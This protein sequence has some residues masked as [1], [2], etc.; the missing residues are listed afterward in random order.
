MEEELHDEDEI[1]HILDSM[2]NSVGNFDCSLHSSNSLKGI[3]LRANSLLW[4]N[5][6]EATQNP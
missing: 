3:I 5:I 1:G 6:F 2:G 4:E